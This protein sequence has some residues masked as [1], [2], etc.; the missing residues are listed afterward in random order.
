M[1]NGFQ[2]TFI[3][4]RGQILSESYNNST[5]TNTDTIIRTPSD[6]GADMDS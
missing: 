4:E 3:K 2:K 6:V 5:D 1:N